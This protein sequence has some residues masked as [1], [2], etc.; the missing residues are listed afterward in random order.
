MFTT[1]ADTLFGTTYL[2]LAP[3]HPLAEA[4]ATPERRAAVAAYIAQARNRPE[5]ERAI[6]A[7]KS[8]VWTGAYA[9]N[10]ITG[11]AVPVWV[12]D[13]VLP[14]AGTG[15]L[16]GVPAHDGRDAAFAA[17]HG[18]P[19]L[20]VVQPDDRNPSEEI[21]EQDGVLTASGSFSGL[22][23]AA[24]R[25]TI[26][27]WLQQR[28]QGRPRVTYR[29]RDWLISRQRYWGPPIPIVYCADCGPQAV[30]EAELPVRLPY[31]EQ[32]RPTGVAPLA[33]VEEFVHTSCPVC[34][35]PAQRETDVSDTFL[36][37]AWYFLRYPS[38]D[39]STYPWNA[40]R[41]ARWLPVDQYA[42][43]P[44]HA[45]MHHLYAR[46]ITRAL[47]DLGHLPFKEPFRR[48]R[49]HG[50]I[51]HGGA[52]MSKSRGNVISPDGYLARYG[53]DV[54]RMYMLFLGPWEEGGDFSDAGI[55]GIA[56][57]VGRV[58]EALRN[59]PPVFSSDATRLSEAA[60][61]RARTITRVGESIA[62]LRF[63]VA[64]AALMEA[65]GWLREHAASLNETAWRAFRR[66]FTLLLAPLAPHLAEELWAVQGEP[67]SV[68]T[69][70]W[71]VAEPA[72]MAVATLEL[73]VQVGGKLRDR[74][75]AP[76]NAD[77]A[78][79]T[80]LALASPRVQAA[81]GG[82]PPTRVVV[83]PGKIV[84]LVV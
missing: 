67:F 13:Y 54:T 39:S 34:G 65:L 38:T 21:Y 75:T 45:T 63:H 69:Q 66:E 78:A 33:A 28:E 40:E 10:P 35:G 19:S 53:T 72:P 44:E 23:S 79:L 26:T 12:A 20:T 47:H 80:A 3:E 82:V 14:G 42:G 60:Q 56:R 32:F 6:G 22:N 15:A 4:I 30:P 25:A 37:S 81:L 41:T 18:L 74:I 84:N 70:P 64:I 36:D 48:L 43:G 9:Q 62:E 83:V 24:A 31:V 17:H 61:L 76:A 58:W 27:S 11:A 55:G 73:A 68:H 8:G 50:T 49:L 29:L 71:P 5:R 57:F 46:F 2:A 77:E 59:P 51:T 1:R 7:E 16:M 52:K